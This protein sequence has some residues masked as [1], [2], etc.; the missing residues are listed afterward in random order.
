MIGGESMSKHLAMLGLLGLLPFEVVGQRHGPVRFPSPGMSG[1]DGQRSIWVGQSRPGPF[2]TPALGAPDVSL[3][4]VA[5]IPPF[6]APAVEGFPR[7]VF[8]PRPPAS[9][10]FPVF[11]PWAPQVA[12]PYGLAGPSTVVIIQQ[13]PGMPLQPPRAEPARS[14]IHEYKPAEPLP[15]EGKPATFVL[16]LTDGSLE[17]AAAVWV[18]AGAVNWI[19]AS[20][21]RR[22]V[23]LDRVDRERTLQRNR[24]RGLRLSLP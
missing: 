14:V 5:P 12:T 3:P 19:D 24:E 8:G 2:R 18:Y 13:A 6:G 15:G 22:S 9:L 17:L 16:V 20:G 21:G 11:L 23:A 10:F 1:G 4:A 7:R